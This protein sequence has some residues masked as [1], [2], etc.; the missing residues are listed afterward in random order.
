MTV[1]D[2]IDALEC[3]DEDERVLIKTCNSMYVDDV[4]T[5]DNYEVRSFYGDDFN[6][7]VICGD[8]QCG[9]I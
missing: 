5:T 1:R 3:Y 7:V 9:A 2:L 4:G 6:A 8:S